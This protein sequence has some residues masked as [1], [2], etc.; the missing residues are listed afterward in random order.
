M[1]TKKKKKVFFYNPRSD[2][3]CEIELNMMDIGMYGSDHSSGYQGND[4]GSSSGYAYYPNHHHHHHHHL[5][6]HP[7]HHN[8]E[9]ASGY[10]SHNNNNNNNNSSTPNTPPTSTSSNSSSIYHPHLYS[11]TAAEYGITTSNQSPTDQAFYDTENSVIQS[12]YNNQTNATEQQQQPS[13]PQTSMHSS[14]SN[15][16]IPDS[17][18]ISSD[19]GL[20]YTN[21]DYMYSQ[22][23]TNAM[24]LQGGDDKST[25]PHL[26]YNSHHS[27]AVDNSTAITVQSQHNHSSPNSMITGTSTVAWQS[28][29]QQQHIGYMDGGSLAAS[30]Q[31]GVGAMT[32]LS[33]QTQMS[34]LNG[35]LNGR[36]LIGLPHNQTDTQLQ[37]Q[38]TQNQQQQ[39][40]QQQPTYKWMQV[41]RNVPK[42]QGKSYFCSNPALT[43]TEVKKKQQTIII[44]QIN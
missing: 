22:N 2:F 21:L 8:T 27:Q 6:H 11:P 40:Q 12:Y 15:S 10:Q 39:Q 37:Q 28:H 30:H 32:C 17:H 34:P 1:H 25:I 14:A 29:P 4:M 23:H 38:P 24:Y 35:S 3:I 44:K 20:S 43:H 33:G 13:L 19:N 18:I 16:V 9:F 5:H 36:G 31:I 26:V 42:P 41:K 7:L